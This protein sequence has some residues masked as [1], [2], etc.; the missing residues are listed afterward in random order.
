MV[1][2]QMTSQNSYMSL[3]LFGLLMPNFPLAL[4]CSQF[5][6]IGEERLSLNL[7]LLSVIKYLMNYS[8][9]ATLNYLTQFSQ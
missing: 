9:V 3:R 1:V 6:R 4:I 8:R 2:A 5:K 7:V